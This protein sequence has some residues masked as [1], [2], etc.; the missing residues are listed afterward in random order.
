M[1]RLAVIGCGYWGPNVIRVF[2]SLEGCELRAACDLD[3]K[4][5][6][7]SGGGRHRALFRMGSP[8]ATL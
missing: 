3:G 7:S 1:I 8:S 4:F 6:G 2:D 5:G